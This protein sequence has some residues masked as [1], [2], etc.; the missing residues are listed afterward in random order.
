MLSNHR[1]AFVMG[2]GLLNGFALRDA[3]RESM[4]SAMTRG[5]RRI[6]ALTPVGRDVAGVIEEIAMDGW[7]ARALRWTLVHAPDRV[8]ALFSMTE[9]LHLGGGAQLDIHAWGT[10][11]LDTFGCL[12]THVPPPRLRTALVGRHQLG[13]LP[14]TVPD[15]NLRIAMAL[16]ELR[17]PAPLTKHVLE[18][19]LHDFLLDVNPMHFDDWLAFVRGARAVRRERIE[20]YLAAAAAAD[21][22]LTPVVATAG[23]LP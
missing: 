10:S 7:R 12:C 15:L 16:H 11:G 13:L 18:A 17:L 8:G 23:R 22:P 5:Q 14:A 1:Q 19:A 6:A 2:L 3:D 20:D 21:G 9:L 4:V